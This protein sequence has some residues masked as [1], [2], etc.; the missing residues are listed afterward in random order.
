[1]EGIISI[2][3]TTEPSRNKKSLGGYGVLYVNPGK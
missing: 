1:M 3:G 2:E